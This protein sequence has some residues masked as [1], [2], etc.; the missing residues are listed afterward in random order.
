MIV[1]APMNEEEL[2]NLM[3][4]AQL[5]RTAKAFSIR[6]PRGQGV[7]PNWR[8]AFKEIEIGKGRKIKEGEGVAILTFGHIGNYAVEACEQLEKQGINPAHYDLR[9]AKPLDEEMLHEIFSSFRKI[10]TVEDGCVQG[11]IG[12]A[13][14][15]FMADNNYSAEVKRLGIPDE[16]VEH[17][18]QIDLYRDCD[19]DSVGIIEAVLSL[20]VSAKAVV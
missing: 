5:P 19:F 18:E 1:A 6:Y 16:I 8:T 9:F 15:E 10:I 14:L 3:F 11:G 2:R 7:M 4:T 20:H 17:G 13:V 12:S